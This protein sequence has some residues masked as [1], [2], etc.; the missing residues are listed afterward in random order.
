MNSQKFL[1]AAEF[2]THELERVRNLEAARDVLTDMGNA[3]QHHQ[4]MENKIN[5]QKKLL[6]HLASQV[7]KSK[8]EIENAERQAEQIIADAKKEAARIVSD[9]ADRETGLVR[10][11]R[12]KAANLEATAKAKVLDLEQRA[13]R[14]SE[15]IAGAAAR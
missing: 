3:E 6:D 8:A 14:L 9:A 12:A 4:Q 2:M 10:T 11:A 5:E 15:A 7:A 1:Q 13:R